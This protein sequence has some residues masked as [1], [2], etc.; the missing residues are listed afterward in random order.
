MVTYEN[1][2]QG[3]VIAPKSENG[4]LQVVNGTFAIGNNSGKT[5]AI[6][7]PD[8]S[9]ENLENGGAVGVKVSSNVGLTYKYNNKKHT[10]TITDNAA[11][12]SK[13]VANNKVQKPSGNKIADKND[14]AKICQYATSLGWKLYNV[15]LGILLDNQSGVSS[16]EIDFPSSGF[17]NGCI[18]VVNQEEVAVNG[19]MTIDEIVAFIDAVN[20]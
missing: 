13:S 10:L 1:G 2:S 5:F 15:K 9:T 19:D 17:T 6:T 14:V 4:T 12:N 20:E 3:I 7:F 11:T 8:G 18:F 16:V